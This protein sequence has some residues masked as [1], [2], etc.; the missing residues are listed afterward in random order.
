[1]SDNKIAATNAYSN[2]QRM[3][4]VIKYN[5]QDAQTNPIVGEMVG[6]EYSESAKSIGD[7]DLY[8]K[9]NQLCTNIQD[10]QDKHEKVEK[11]IQTLM[12][13]LKTQ[14]VINRTSGGKYQTVV[15]NIKQAIQFA[16]EVSD[17]LVQKKLK[18]QSSQYLQNMEEIKKLG[19]TLYLSDPQELQLKTL[20]NEVSKASKTSLE[21]VRYEDEIGYVNDEEKRIADLIVD[22][23]IFKCA[24]TTFDTMAGGKMW[25]QL[26]SG[27]LYKFNN[28]TAQEL[29]GDNSRILIFGP[30]GSGK[31][32]L[33]ESMVA[34]LMKNIKRVAYFHVSPSGLASKFPAYP[35][36]GIK[37]L[38]KVM[39]QYA[40]APKKMP[41]IGPQMVVL[42]M[43]QFELFVHSPNNLSLYDTFTAEM[44]GMN[45]YTNVLIMVSTDDPARVMAEGKTRFTHKLFMPLP[46]PDTLREKIIVEAQKIGPHVC[47][48]TNVE[49][50]RQSYND[51]EG[52]SY[53][54]QIFD[55][56][57]TNQFFEELNKQKTSE[58]KLKRAKQLLED[59]HGSQSDQ[60]DAIVSLIYEKGANNR[61][62]K[63]LTSKVM[64]NVVYKS[65]MFF[66]TFISD[67][68]SALHAASSGQRIVLEDYIALV[69]KVGRV[70]QRD[71]IK[72]EVTATQKAILI[73]F[74][75]ADAMGSLIVNKDLLKNYKFQDQ[76]V[77]RFVPF[78]LYELIGHI[79]GKTEFLVDYK[80]YDTRDSY[81]RL[82]L[83]RRRLVNVD[84]SRG[85]VPISEY[86]VIKIQNASSDEF[87][88]NY[89]PATGTGLKWT[90]ISQGYDVDNVKRI[91]N[92]LNNFY[93]GIPQFHFYDWL[94]QVNK[95]PSSMVDS[96]KLLS[97]FKYAYGI[98][99]MTAFDSSITKNFPVNVTIHNKELM[100]QMKQTFQKIKSAPTSQYMKT[101]SAVENMKIE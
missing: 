100:Q 59:K 80:Q 57:Y 75:F 33:A 16:F 47:G 51:S 14:D 34:E 92:G 99:D 6:D 1:M 15:D 31:G 60:I 17:K 94:E 98:D 64:E 73:P 40:A 56:T 5:E 48:F 69:Y 74:A 78:Y 97:S 10:I 49:Y 77:E 3:N 4:R 23:M 20:R 83:V 45:K 90:D 27:L 79:D 65:E 9:R 70:V 61:Q 62:V 29:S 55:P 71:E 67:N 54:Q 53:G 82:V 81:E 28:P 101:K 89:N 46:S 38:F 8:L 44:E 96:H 39:K 43:D 35:E 26:L 19:L 63:E 37:A 50:K 76:Q 41:E 52:T 72:C 86:D 13:K 36:A 22:S 7:A 93:D 25:K 2:T 95:L 32:V 21:P 12:N 66:K 42:Y 30:P 84:I 24:F 11:A 88:A 87:F 68:I 85:V 58:D 18:C 91:V